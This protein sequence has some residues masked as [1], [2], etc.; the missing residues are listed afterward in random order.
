ML[1]RFFIS[2]L[3]TMTGL[4]LS[5]LVL[6]LGAMM[7]M[8]SLI[9]RGGDS[10][11]VVKEKSILYFN[12]SG[13][14]AERYEPNDFMTFLRNG[15]SDG[16]L[17]LD[18]MIRSLKAAADD[19]MIEGLYLNCSGA[20]IG[21]ASV[22]ELMQAIAE[23]KE[24]GKWIVAYADSYEQGDY[25]IATSADDEGLRLNPLGTINV[26]GVGGTTPFY[27]GLLDKLGVKMQIIKV[28]TFKSAVEPYI[29]TSMSEPARLQMQQYV[30]SIWS[31]L[32][33]TISENRNLPETEIRDLASQ[34]LMA[35]KGE[36]FIENKLADKLEYRRETEKYLK[37]LCGLKDDDELRLVSPSDYLENRANPMAAEF[38]K[39][40]VAVYYAVG[41]IVDSGEQGIVGPKVVDD[42]IKLA[43]NDKVKGLVLRV[44][45]PGGSAF[46]SEQIWEALQ[47]FKSTEKPLYVSM[48]DYAASGGYYI[49]CGADT[50]FADRTTLTGSIGVFGM[51]PDLS[52]LVTGKLGVNFSTVESNP[53][54]AG[55][56]GLQAMTPY[57]YQAMQQSVEDIYD[58]FTGRVAAGRGM[59]VDSVKAIAE[60]RVWTG[61]RAIQLGLVDRI[62]TL[63]DAVY[64]MTRRLHLKSDKYVQYPK[65]EE[66]LWEKMLRQSGQLDV[67]IES[68]LDAE[69]VEALRTVKRLREA[70]P[71]QA[72]MED[73]VLH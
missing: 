55:I 24:S 66:K 31:Y 57:Q 9:A 13:T 17:T 59:N 7:A 33:G 28:G 71:I 21:S 39:D 68:E 18:D 62:G 22:E 34:M 67:N 73:I 50:I 14:V 3:G 69:T 23:F 19:D 38:A 6:F 65:H 64:A 43:D 10:G 41:D 2:V 44:N 45:S 15:A 63:D 40:H 70:A 20:A 12:L 29:L 51:I 53:N 47:Y 46:A 11:I 42:I 48:G 8:S 5:V 52:G 36:F 72:R 26:H 35:K 16:G 1:K 4:W 49:S 54:A 61:S 56:T 60:G 27:K 37:Q 32:S 30:D 25:V 58:L